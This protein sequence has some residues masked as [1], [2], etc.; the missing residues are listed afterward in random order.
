MVPVRLDVHVP[1]R[2]R[3]TRRRCSFSTQHVLPLKPLRFAYSFVSEVAKRWT[4]TIERPLR[5]CDRWMR[6]D[7]G[8]QRILG[9]SG[10][11]AQPDTILGG[12]ACSAKVKLPGQRACKTSLHLLERIKF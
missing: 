3:S 1:H 6:N 11:K 10:T 5:E 7:H 4:V 8:G 12:S 2:R 9:I